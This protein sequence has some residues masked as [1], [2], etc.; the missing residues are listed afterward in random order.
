M[1]TFF[2]NRSKRESAMWRR[3]DRTL[4]HSEHIQLTSEQR[5]VKHTT[6]HTIQGLTN[7]FLK[8]LPS[9]K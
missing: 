6:Q 8:H 2:F 4:Q 7:T 3:K 9:G 1:L 5:E